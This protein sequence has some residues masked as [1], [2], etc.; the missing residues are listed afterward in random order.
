MGVGLNLSNDVAFAQ[1][2]VS[3]YVLVSLNEK[4]LKSIA[5]LT[6]FL[7]HVLETIQV[8]WNAVHTTADDVGDTRPNR[9]RD[10]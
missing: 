7:L 9:A 8:F 2:D 6:A 10:T 5:A 3:S 4:L 1:L